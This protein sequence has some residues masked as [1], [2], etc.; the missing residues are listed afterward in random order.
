MSAGPAF[1]QTIGGSSGSDVYS[2]APSAGGTGVTGSNG[3]DGTSAPSGGYGTGGGGGGAGG[4]TGGSGGGSGAGSGGSGGTSSSINGGDGGTATGQGGGGGGGGGYNGNGAGVSALSNATPLTGGAGG[5][6]GGELA[7]GANGSGGGGGGAGG[8]GAIV[9]G[10]SSSSNTNTISGGTGGNGGNGNTGGNGGGGGGGLYFSATGANFTNASTGSITGGAGGNGGHGGNSVGESNGGTGGAGGI[11]ISI[12][13]TVINLGDITGGQGG[14]GGTT[15]GDTAGNGGAGGAGAS[16]GSGTSLTLGTNARVIG[17]NGGSGGSIVSFSDGGSGGNGGAGG[18]GVSLGSGGTLTI[19]TGASVTGGNGGAPGAGVPG[20][21]AGAGG[22][23]VVGSDLTIINA[24]TI[25]GGFANNGAGAQNYAIELT[26][27][28]NSVGYGGTIN[29]GIDVAGGS[30]TPAATGSAVGT[31]LTITGPLTF[32]AGTTYTVRIT[33]TANDSVVA[34]GTATLTGANVFVAAGAGTYTTGQR[35]IITANTLA[36]TFTGVTSNLAFLAPTLAYDATHVY[37]DITGNTS[38]GS[39]DYRTAAANRNQFAL[40]SALTNAGANN[41]NA[42][43]ITGLNQLTASQAQAAF[44][45]LSGEGITA[46]DTAGLQM[47]ALFGDAMSDQTTLWLDGGSNAN[48]VVL[49]GPPPGVLFYAPV[50]KS[51]IVVHDPLLPPVRTWRAWASGF[52]ADETVHGVASLGTT[53]QSA[54]LYGGAMGIDYQIAPDLLFGV[55]GGGSNGNF[56]VPGRATYGSVTG[57]HIGTYGVATFGAFYAA[58]A[59]SLSFFHNSETRSLTGFGGLAG[60]TD[61][62]AYNSRAARTRLEVGRRFADVYG[63][64]ITPFVALEIADLRANGFS[65]TPTMG[66]GA[67]ALNVQGR[68]TASVPAYLGLRFEKLFYLG[69]GMSLK[70]VLSLAYGHDFAPERQITNALLGLAADPFE[71]DGARLAR[72][73]ARTKAGFELTLAPNAMAFAN[74]DG[75]FSGRDQLYGGKGGVKLIW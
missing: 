39:I 26:G 44:N 62:G 43:I 40:A 20:G 15:D 53:A 3:S 58:S 29:G 54:E 32:A 72:D 63:A 70:P 5:N 6:G 10:T 11:G 21:A 48:A 24:G 66:T 46:A 68:D 19:G 47:N 57:G 16:L 25:S 31:P 75:E 28:T 13:G 27:G 52:G 59:T 22:V 45:S 34:T 71:I 17:G 1:S 4:G 18:V 61:H 2:D 50:T 8:Y 38:N 73:F 49:T 55:A 30:F 7:S 35:T 9:T 69:S 67:F 12:S 60:E 14:T 56:S 65:E 64:T 42:P 37:L 41:P 33:P 74:F 51:P 23:G 36:G